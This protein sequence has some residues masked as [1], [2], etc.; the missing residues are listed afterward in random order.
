MLILAEATNNTFGAVN[1]CGAVFV[2]NSDSIYQ[3]QNRAKLMGNCYGYRCLNCFWSICRKRLH[4]RRIRC[5]CF[6]KTVHGAG[7]FKIG[8][9]I[10]VTGTKA[11]RSSSNKS[12]QSV[13]YNESLLSLSTW[14]SKW[15]WQIT[16]QNWYALW[17]LSF[18]AGY[19][20]WNSSI[21]IE[22]S[23]GTAQLCV[24]MLMWM[25]L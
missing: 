22:W 5:S 9:S 3:L 1:K 2:D 6:D 14:S 24:L 25:I 17:T 4:S 23:N 7:L 15:N 19:A 11:P 18:K 10:T 21:N 16:L 8:D 13:T 20:I 12:S